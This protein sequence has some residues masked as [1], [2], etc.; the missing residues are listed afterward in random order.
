MRKIFDKQRPVHRLNLKKELKNK[1]DEIVK[2]ILTSNQ[3][4]GDYRARG[5]NFEVLTKYN[6]YLY[7]LLIKNSRKLLNSFTI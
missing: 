5:Y 3:K 1:K 4:A 7:N 2:D 6:D